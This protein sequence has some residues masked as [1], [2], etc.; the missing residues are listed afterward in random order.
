[1]S[2]P[3]LPYKLEAYGILCQSSKEAIQV[4]TS[5]GSQTFRPNASPL[6]A[7]ALDYLLLLE[8]TISTHSYWSCNLSTF[9]FNSPDISIKGLCTHRISKPLQPIHQ[10]I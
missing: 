5:E 8:M 4:G 9:S 3:E 7:L 6:L 1:M 10:I 2:L